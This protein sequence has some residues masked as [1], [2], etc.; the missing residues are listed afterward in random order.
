M[1]GTMCRFM[2]MGPELAQM[3]N[4]TNLTD[5]MA[6]MNIGRWMM[7]ADHGDKSGAALVLMN[8][9]TSIQNYIMPAGLGIALVFFLLDMLEKSYQNIAGFSIETLLGPF[10][11]LIVTVFVISKSG[12]I[13][14]LV[15]NLSDEFSAIGG[16]ILN[17]GDA[18]TETENFAKNT[19]NAVGI[20][21]DFEV[22]T[23]LTDAP[24]AIAASY[25]NSWW[26]YGG[27]GA[28]VSLQLQNGETDLIVP[29]EKV[30]SMHAGIIG[31]ILVFGKLLFIQAIYWFTTFSLFAIILKRFVE[32]YV[33]CSMFPLA[34][35]G[36]AHGGTQS[37]GFRF[38]L[39]TAGVGL[40]GM[41][42]C[43]VIEALFLMVAYEK[44]TGSG[45]IILF[46]LLTQVGTCLKMVDDIST[47]VLG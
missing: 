1:N 16:K 47:K 19:L 27:K 28:G 41:L 33:R 46:I 29:G 24:D 7:L 21:D 40:R 42:Y 45:H 38:I 36:T 17:Y 5:T 26:T 2:D 13:T 34:L 15:A 8:L 37:Q 39:E 32:F 20:N 43:I 10:L 3:I 6:K 12:E 9:V 25:I 11:K 14:K 44:A 4:K 31:G 23:T 30:K 18:D 35:A 22:F